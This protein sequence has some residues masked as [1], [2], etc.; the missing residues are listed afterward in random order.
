[1]LESVVRGRPA[2]ALGGSLDS[3]RQELRLTLVVDF[4][5]LF[6][7]AVD[8]GSR[9]D[10]VT[11]SWPYR[12]AKKRRPWGIVDLSSR[13]RGCSGHPVMSHIKAWIVFAAALLPSFA[14]ACDEGLQKCR[15]IFG[16]LVSYRAEAIERAF[17]DFRPVMPK[18]I[19]IKYV[20]PRDDE[21]E[22]YSRRVAYDLE[23]EVLVVPRFMTSARI[24]NPLRATANYWPFYQNELYRERFPL[25]LAI[26]NA[27]WGAYLQEA[28]QEKGLS[29][30]HE[31]CQSVDIGKRLACEML[32]EGIAAQLTAIRDPLFNENRMDRIWP[33]DF[34]S[35][36]ERVWR[37]D[38]RRYLEV[39]RYGGLML[40]KPL[41]DRYGAPSALFY[42]AQTPFEIEDD[43]LRR[44]ALRYQE[45]AREWLEANKNT[46]LNDVT[47]V[48]T[49]PLK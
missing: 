17:G 16:E 29:W 13:W 30:P 48:S 27:L 20:G 32:V 19:A 2:A 24:P 47:V 42:F 8:R 46:K 4:T 5:M 43:D 34:R 9:R 31:N 25:V 41:I 23:Q 18:R 35:F 15:E 36:R 6:A 40:V 3:H 44:S 12:V 11:P 28:A 49:D 26:D 1:M 22:L 14:V 38:D 39:Q 7:G 10:R 21:Y 33:S 45:R 37:R